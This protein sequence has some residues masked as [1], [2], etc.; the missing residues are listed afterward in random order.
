LERQTKIKKKTASLG[1]CHGEF[2]FEQC[3]TSHKTHYRSYWGRVF[4][5]QTT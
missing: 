4:T 2:E 3:L 1:C 5:S